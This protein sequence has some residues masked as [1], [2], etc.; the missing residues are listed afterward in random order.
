MLGQYNT[1]VKLVQ[2]M[3]CSVLLYVITSSSYHGN[4]RKPIAEKIES[5]EEVSEKRENEE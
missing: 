5:K 1:V 3:Y 4:A 2:Q